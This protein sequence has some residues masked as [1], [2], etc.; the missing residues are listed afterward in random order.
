MQ[1]TDALAIVSFL[2]FSLKVDREV[3]EQSPY[4]KGIA[5][6]EVIQELEKNDFPLDLNINREG[7]RADISTKGGIK[8]KGARVVITL[9]RPSDSSL[10]IQIE[11]SEVDDGVYE[12]KTEI[13]PGLWISRVMI[14]ARGIKQRRHGNVMIN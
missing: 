10:D 8:L 5:Y 7:I 3:V 2:I 14:E 1:I 12:A 4:E 11:L 9:T 13:K 6:Q